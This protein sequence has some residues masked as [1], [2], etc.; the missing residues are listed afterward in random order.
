MNRQVVRHL[1]DTLIDAG[2]QGA[3][4]GAAD[5]GR[6]AVCVRSVLAVA[7][8][9]NAPEL[10]G[11]VPVAAAPNAWEERGA[12]PSGTVKGADMAVGAASKADAAGA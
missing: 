4:V 2:A 3:T 6:V 8:E 11:A 5:A 10:N 12:V 7:P 1:G 9:A